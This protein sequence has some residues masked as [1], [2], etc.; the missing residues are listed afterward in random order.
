MIC[1]ACTEPAVLSWERWASEEEVAELHA[2]G[3]LPAHETTA[4]L[5]VGGCKKHV[6]DL[7]LAGLVHGSDCTA[8]PICDC[9]PGGGGGG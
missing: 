3:D 1:H 6:L 2:S 7:E 5:P 4:K 8:P 9:E